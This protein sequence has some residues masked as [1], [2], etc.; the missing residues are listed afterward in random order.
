[1]TEVES[2]CAAKE[3]AWRAIGHAAVDKLFRMGIAVG[4][5]PD[6]DPVAV[7]QL[8]HDA[9]QAIDKNLLVLGVVGRGDVDKQENPLGGSGA[10]GGPVNGLGTC[11]GGKGNQRQNGE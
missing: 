3:K 4:N 6:D 8:A 10:I 1:M 2:G 11:C 9:L 7:A 5:R